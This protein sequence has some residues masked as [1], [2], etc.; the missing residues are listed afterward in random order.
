MERNH[1]DHL[2]NE[3]DLQYYEDFLNEAKEAPKFACNI[4]KMKHKNNAVKKNTSS[5]LHEFLHDHIGKTVRIEF[6]VG[7]SKEIRTGR[8]FKVGK[9]YIVLKPRQ[10]NQTIVCDIASIKFITVIH[11]F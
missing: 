6:V 5:A 11:N 2:H 8:L 7:N 4:D 10:S 3:K 9:E 1:I